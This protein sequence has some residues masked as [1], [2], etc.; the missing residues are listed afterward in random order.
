MPNSDTAVPSSAPARK[1]SGP[2]AISAT[3]LPPHR[4]PSR[5][6]TITVISAPIRF[7]PVSPFASSGSFS[8]PELTAVRFRA[9][10]LRGT[11]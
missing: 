1:P 6:L 9:I 5:T 2:A 4:R 7:M 8:G 10:S 3:P 11:S